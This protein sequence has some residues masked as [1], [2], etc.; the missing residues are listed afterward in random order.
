MATASSPSTPQVSAAGTRAGLSACGSA[1]SEDALG[2]ES[3]WDSAAEPEGSPPALEGES[4]G[5][6]PFV[7]PLSAPFLPVPSPAPAGPA[8]R[9]E[10]PGDSPATGDP[11]GLPDAEAETDA[12][13]DDAGE[14]E[15][16]LD[17]GLGP[18]P[19]EP[20]PVPPEGDE[21]LLGEEPPVDPPEPLP[22]PD[23]LPDPLPPGL[24]EAVGEVVCDG[25]D[26]GVGEGDDVGVE[27]FIRGGATA[28]GT[29]APAAR[30]CCHDQPTDPPAGTV[31]EPTPYDEYVQDAF[32]PS[33]H[34]RP[35][36]ALA[37]EAF[38]H[39]SLVG[40]PLTRHTKPG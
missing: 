18:E 3:V 1:A 13:G 17:D 4:L 29:L 30:S 25:V 16:G 35:Q 14:A 31:S 24:G 12:E 22:L 20:L 28:G 23:P 10:S 38:T 8:L 36:Y 27:V 15:D 37:G 40:T 39:G 7:E 19:P 2:T 5:D 21:G 34:H 26:V 9:R 6:S 33:A 11:D 32:E